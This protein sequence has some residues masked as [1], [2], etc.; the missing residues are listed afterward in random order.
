VHGIPTSVAV[1][2]LVAR[3]IVLVLALWR[4]LQRDRAP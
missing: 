2:F 1:P 3:V 4:I